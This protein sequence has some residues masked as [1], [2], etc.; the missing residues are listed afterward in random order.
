MMLHKCNTMLQ[1]VVVIDGDVSDRRII[2]K[3]GNDVH[4]VRDRSNQCQQH[5]QNRQPFRN[6]IWN[7]ALLTMT[8]FVLPAGIS[9]VTR[10]PE[11]RREARDE[12]GMIDELR[13]EI[14]DVSVRAP[15]I[16]LIHL[17][18]WWQKSSGLSV[19]I[20]V[21]VDICESINDLI[22]TVTKA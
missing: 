22:R 10:A 20:G 13:R 12:A 16:S 3:L 4:L 5:K 14:V 2:V 9:R 6:V 21:V 17:V 19:W 8:Y 7:E 11:E 1:D 15:S 18:D